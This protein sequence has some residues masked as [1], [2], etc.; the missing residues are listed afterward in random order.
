MP[1]RNMLH[2][3]SESENGLRLHVEF[4]R[5]DGGWDSPYPI[6]E[7]GGYE[8][9]LDPNQARALRIRPNGERRADPW[10]QFDMDR[11]ALVH[12]LLIEARERVQVA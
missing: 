9:F 10:M 3:H 8:F 2:G 5:S 6:I 7:D 4:S 1:D 12:R 11:L